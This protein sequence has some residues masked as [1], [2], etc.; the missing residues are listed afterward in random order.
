LKQ[1]ALAEV[2]GIHLVLQVVKVRLDKGTTVVQEVQNFLM[3]VAA[4]AQVAL[5]EI[6]LT[7]VV[8]MEETDYLVQFLVLR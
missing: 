8:I 7:I 4:E 6:E 2:L 1:E 3:A 5:E